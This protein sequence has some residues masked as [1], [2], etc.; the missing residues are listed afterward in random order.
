MK[1]DDATASE[2]SQLTLTP[3]TDTEL[4]TPQA[5]RSQLQPLRRLATINAPSFD[6]KI[7]VLSRTKYYS[8]PN[9]FDLA[10]RHTPE[11]LCHTTKHG[12]FC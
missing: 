9:F 1:Q 10:V 5:R 11:A 7:S 6:S 3:Q 8:S 4:L 12:L 2:T